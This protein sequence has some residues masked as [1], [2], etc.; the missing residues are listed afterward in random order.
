MDLTKKFQRVAS[1]VAVNFSSLDV[2]WKYPILHVERIVTKFGPTVLMT[3]ADEPDRT[4]KVF[5]PK[6][7]SSE[8][9]DVDITDINSTKVSL[10]L[11]Y[12]GVCE[13]SKSYIL[14]IAKQD[15]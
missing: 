10:F 14:A 13:K 2:N 9:S 11:I 5:L 4:M 12:K 7:Y 8:I 15:P 3:L 6:R 1:S